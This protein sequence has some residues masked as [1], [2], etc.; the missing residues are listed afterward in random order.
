MRFAYRAA[1]TAGFLA[2][3]LGTACAQ[4][5]APAANPDRTLQLL[6]G[7]AHALE[8]RGRP[9]MAIQLWQQIL[10]SDPRNTEALAGLARDYK[11]SGQ[12]AKS[13][14]ALEKLRSVSP[15]DP[16]IARIQALAS[17]ST[18]SDRLRQAGNLARQ[19][20]NEDAMRIY[21]DLYG[22]RPPDGDIA[23]AYYQTL[24][25]TA[26][27]KETAINA[28]RALAQRNPG[29]PRFAVELGTMLTYEART[30]AEGIKILEAHPGDPNA[31]SALRQAL[32]WDSANPASAAELRQYLKEHPQDTELTARLKENE[33]KLA[34]MN[35][36]IARTPAERAAF[37]ALNAHRLEEAQTRFNEI[38]E[39]E[40]AN[41]RAEAGMGF[42]RMQQNNFG[43]AISYLTQAEQNGYKNPTVESALATSRF[44]Y[45]M[46]EASQAF[47]ENNLELAAAKYQEALA[48]R[49]KSKEALNGFAGLLTKQQQYSAAATIYEN[50]LKQDPHNR[51]AWRGLFLAYARDGQNDKALAITGRFPAD[52]K[53]EMAKDPEYLRTLATIY[54]AQNRPADA[55]RVLSQALALPFPANGANLKQDTRLQYAGILMEAHRFDQAAAMYTQILNDDAGNPPAW[56]GLVSAHHELNRDGDA[57]ADVEKM[58]PATYEAALSD[59]GFL[60]ML[61]SIYQ[62]ANQFDIAQNLLERAAK[63][64]MAAGIQPSL[65][66]QLQLASIYLQRNNTAQAYGIYRQVLTAHPDRIDAWKGLI[67]TLQSTNHTTEA[68]QQIA[69]IPPAVRKQLESDAEFVE[70]EASLYAAAGDIPHAAEYMSRVQAHYAALK[71]PM[72]TNLDIQNAWLLYN[73]KHDRALYPALM[74][75]GSRQDLTATQ[76]E[77]VQTIWANW[78]VRR[79]G[80]AIDNNDNQRAVEILEA[81]SQSFPDN[82]QVRKV[83]AGGY[84]RTGQTKEALAIYRS[85]GMQDA[86][87]ADFQGAIGAALAANDKAQ[88]EL[89]LRQGLER[90]PTDANILAMAARFEQARGD[91]QR[92]A[93]YWR[94]SLAA[95]PQ[96]TPTDRLAHDLAYPDVNTKPHKAANAA[97][98]QRLL[99]PNYEPFQKT[100]KLPPLPAYGPDPYNGTTPVV[101][102]QPQQPV[103]QQ[104]GMVTAPTTTQIQVPVPA[105]TRAANTPPPMPQVQGSPYTQSASSAQLTMQGTGT[106]A[107][108]GLSSNA[109][110][111]RKRR[112]HGKNSGNS[113][114]TGQMNLPP[115]DVPG[116]TPESQAP[117]SSQTVRQT[118]V[119]IPAP[120]PL[121]PPSTQA[122]PDSLPLPPPAQ[123]SN[124][125]QPYTAPQGQTPLAPQ[126][127]PGWTPNPQSS[128]TPPQSSGQPALRITREPMGD[129]AAQI[130][131]QFAD[132]VDGQLT[133]GS[134]S[135]IRSLGNAP[136]TLP[137]DTRSA[138]AYSP[139][140]YTPSAQEAATGAYSARKQQQNPQT[141]QPAQTNLPAAQPQATQQSSQQ[142]GTS[143]QAGTTQKPKSGRRRATRT[144][145]VPTLVTAPGEESPQQVQVAPQVQPSTVPETTAPETALPAPSGNAGATTEGLSDEELE[146]RALPP[147]RGPWVRVQRQKQPVS[148]REEAEQQLESLESGYSPW[149]GGTGVIN[150]R[151]GNLGYD[152]LSALE[153]PF[154][155]STPFGYN[156]RLTIVAR[157]VFLDS[158]QADG[159]AITT[160]QEASTS[161][162]TLVTIPTPLGTDTNTGATPTTTS[163]TTPATPPAQQNAAGVA[164]EVQ[165]AFPHLAL[166][167]GYT[168]YGFLVSNVTGR[169]QWRPENG[170]FTFSFIRDSVKDTQLSYGGLRD[171]GNA[172][173]SFPGSVWG[174]VVA[175]QG[176]IQF[177]RGDAQSGFYLGVGGQYLTGYNVE[178]NTRIDGSG[179]A[180]W[181]VKSFPEYGTLSIGANFFGMHYSHNE[182]AFT[183]GLGGYFSP[184]E[185]FLA[186]VPFTWSGHYMTRW[187]YEILGGFGVQAFQQELTPLFPLAAQKATEVGLNNAAIP[188]LTSVGPNYNLRSTVAYQI[189]PHWFAGGFLSANNS[190]N[191]ASVTAGFSI[192][193][194]FRA[195]PSTVTSPT[196]LFPT[197][198]IRPF[199]VP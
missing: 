86:S 5:Q 12:S 45:T 61:G 119:F 69:L 139:T 79:A 161:G 54:H 98:L 39:K 44:W 70:G 73:T 176:N 103:A 130:Q 147:L 19:G 172:S 122:Q 149:M 100:T 33:T 66:M 2:L 188:A 181:R 101:I 195:Q 140:Q 81:A 153:A 94:A 90:F 88:A 62:Q 68:L 156:A 72:P 197:E 1:A 198:G 158:G 85:I 127:Q 15:N 106:A 83:L 131:A 175:N 56:M 43:G 109:T 92:A 55:Q 51:D 93:D 192:H 199:T 102:P 183:Y 154:E 99:D 157:P 84:L 146:Q 104:S 143:G 9:D 160:V 20:K 150:Y 42:L 31:G 184:Q 67:A 38:L 75:L 16:N 112:A 8:S 141:T 24:Y 186:N 36:G 120:E 121:S 46:G 132:Q 96:A 126:A 162:T 82:M 91:N 10:L 47:T 187:H 13:D 27:G 151:S 22:D 196:G 194:L 117:A 65:Q 37:A 118:P 128:V 30:R 111:T 193:Y 49:P 116:T 148:P 4:R 179:G 134:A 11:L 137:G 133:Q 77:T 17:T 14:E 159:T 58:P 124:P 144:E 138:N 3:C 185:Y 113:T 174:G 34:E 80:T 180:Y 142:T 64:Q 57:I 169:A 74:R 125:P 136:V 107:S 52:V 41:S 60:S 29:D 76:R 26:G 35:S 170:P 155:V 168:P 21:R 78:S 105:T 32:I 191:Y 189:G 53:N 110:S 114:Y 23:L 7:N 6:I 145:T 123:Q 108:S 177:S 165:L 129:K 115:S 166:A 173:L 48:M 171:P 178:S 71:Q 28:M 135:Q 18:Q 152:H 50:L 167:A 164:G 87:A 190:R 95:M 40:P 89:W 163:T 25:G 97:D 63:L 182:E 59:V